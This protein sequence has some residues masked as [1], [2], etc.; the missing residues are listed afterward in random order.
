MTRAVIYMRRSTGKQEMSIERQRS[1]LHAHADRSSIE[2]VGEYVDDAITGEVMDERPQLMQLIYRDIR[3]EPRAFDMIMADCLDRIS[4]DKV[5]LGIIFRTTEFLDVTVFTLQDQVCNDDHATMRGWMGKKE[6]EAI[7][8]RVRSAHRAKVRERGEWPGRA[9]YGYQSV[10]V[11]GRKGVLKTDPYQSA[12]VVRIY[13]MYRDGFSPRAICL[14]LSNE[15]VPA[16]YGGRWNRQTIIGGGPR[17]FGILNNPIYV[18]EIIR[19]QNRKKR[20]DGFSG[21]GRKKVKRAGKPEDLVQ[22]SAPHLRIVSPELK[23]A[24]EKIRAGRSQ[25]SFPNGKRKSPH[26]ARSQHLLAGLAQCGVCGGPMRIRSASGGAPYASCT[27][28]EV[29]GTCKHMR[30][31]NLDKLQIAVRKNAREE[32]TSSDAIKRGIREHTTEHAKR[33]KESQKEAAVVRRELDRNTAEQARIA[34]AIAR[35]RRRNPALENKLDQLEVEREGL[36]KRQEFV[37]AETNVVELHPRAEEAYLRAVEVFTQDPDTVPGRQAFR[38]IVA[39]IVIKPLDGDDGSAARGVRR[40]Y[41][42]SLLFRWAALLGGADPMP[43]AGR[44][45]AE[46]LKHQGVDPI[47]YRQA[48][49][50]ETDT[51]QKLIALGPWTVAA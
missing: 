31:Y 25:Q 28:A 50:L 39:G 46:I 2:I 42:F 35:L 9:P 6:L 32:L 8:Y 12:V 47:V 34:D 14:I 1:E 15:G 20:T 33:Q 36:L 18:G 51:I 3:R 16:P 19:G 48:P 10:V 24:V 44:S 22:R 13:E 29:H 30:T 5:D 49:V 4:R 43:A 37:G 40:G 17:R 11:D 38:N 45:R 27:A 23:A 41:K 26:V 7:A 21:S